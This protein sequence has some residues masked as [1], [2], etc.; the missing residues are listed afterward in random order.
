MIVSGATGV[1]KTYV[2]CA[3]AQ[4]ACRKG[5]LAIYRRASRLLDELVLARADGSYARLLAMLARGDVLV[6]DDWEIA[7]ARDQERHD[8]LEVLEDRYGTR[9]TIF[10]SQLP[11][12]KWHEYLGEPTVADAILDRLVHNAPSSCSKDHLEERRKAPR[13]NQTPRVAS[14][15]LG[16]SMSETVNERVAECDGS[17][18]YAQTVGARLATRMN[19][20]CQRTAAALFCVRYGASAARTEDALKV[21]H[22]PRLRWMQHSEPSSRRANQLSRSLRAVQGCA[23]PAGAP[24]RVALGSRLRR[25]RSRVAHSGRR[26]FLGSV[27]RP[28][29]RG[30]PGARDARARAHPGGHRRQGRHRGPAVDRFAV[31]YPQHPNHRAVPKWKRDKASERRD[32]GRQHRARPRIVRTEAHRSGT[33]PADSQAAWAHSC[34]VFERGARLAGHAHSLRGQ[35]LR[36]LQDLGRGGSIVAANRNGESA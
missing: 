21:V 5:Y 34:R 9:S 25:A 7:P 20:S 4:Q 26:R 1:G 32:V 31:R 18:I 29:S 6:V 14:L 35:R 10:A 12:S 27:V 11:V 2:A 22:D 16:L 13:S 19:T 36:A 30:R 33:R 3:L 8:L 28:L 23:L 15:R 24:A 17:S